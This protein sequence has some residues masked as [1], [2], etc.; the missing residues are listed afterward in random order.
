MLEKIKSKLTK[1]NI[2]IIGYFILLIFFVTFCLPLLFFYTLFNEDKVKQMVISQINNKNYTVQIGGSVEPRSW[3]GMTL[4]VSD[5]TVLDKSNHKIL[6]VNTAKC[7][8][9]WPNLILAKYKI[10]RVALNGLTFYQGNIEKNGITNLINYDNLGNSEFSGLKQLNVTN[11]TVIDANESA[12]IKD[13]A[14]LVT[15]L[16]N[17]KPEFNL[18]FNLT[19]YGAQVNFV[20]MLNKIDDTPHSMRIERLRFKVNNPKYNIQLQSDGVYDYQTQEFWFENARGTVNL[21]K[22]QGSLAVDSALISFYGITINS[23]QSTLNSNIAHNTQSLNVSANKLVTRGFS[24]LNADVIMAEFINKNEDGKFIANLKLDKPVLKR[25]L[26]VSNQNCA[27]SYKYNM[28][29]TGNSSHGE[30]AGDCE[31]IG[32]QGL[33][34]LQLA[35]LLD[36]SAAKFNMNYNYSES[37]PSVALNGNIDTLKLD[38]LLVKRDSLL[39]PSYADTRPLPFKWLDMFNAEARLT[40]NQLQFDN[41]ILN[42]LSGDFT[43][44]NHIFQLKNISANTYDGVMHGS[45]RV[46][47]INESYNIALSENITGVNLRKFFENLFNV[48]AISGNANV[49]IN[50]NVS[51]VS[52]YRDI[53]HKLNGNVLFDVKNGGFSGIDFS[54]F[55][56]PENLAAFNK[57]GSIKTGFT[58]LKAS[59]DFSNGI[60]NKGSINFSSPTISASG[61]GVANFVDNQINYDLVIKSILP[62]NAQ[63]IKSVSIPVTINGELFN[64][65]FNIRNMTL[66]HTVSPTTNKKINNRKR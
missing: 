4:F 20:G 24:G 32:S 6:H 39:L 40:V 60:S 26:S 44:K 61:G 10:R 21:P 43:V 36:G 59:F 66:N 9:S 49:N 22:Y 12:I 28:S 57:N 34:K 23:L 33:L 2:R 48:S 29:R 58:G 47:K 45:A 17:D 62:N 56:S 30:F 38:N 1:R 65:K 35:G 16:D 64:P 51:G 14:L 15:N 63:N 41:F 53:Y 37:M 54:I 18:D 13:A 46:E 42:N 31:F 52:S 25:N 3:H 55:L 5:L 11:L 8:L 7:Q 27:V 19:Q 50:T